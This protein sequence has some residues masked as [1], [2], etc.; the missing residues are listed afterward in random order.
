ME[1]IHLQLEFSVPAVAEQTC[2]RRWDIFGAVD[3]LQVLGQNDSAFKLD[4]TRIGGTKEINGSSLLPKMLPPALCTSGDVIAGFCFAIEE[5]GE[6][7]GKGKLPVR[8]L[9][10]YLVTFMGTCGRRGA[11]R[12]TVGR[13]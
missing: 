1:R 9:H 4:C 3:R 12:S 6:L 10:P 11:F 13:I 5:T 2:L 8:T 7:Y